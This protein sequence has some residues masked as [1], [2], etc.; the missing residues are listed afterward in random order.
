MSSPAKQ[1]TTPHVI[2]G[3]L[4]DGEVTP[5][6]KVVFS[7]KERSDG[8]PLYDEDWIQNLIFKYPN[9][10]PVQD[11]EPAFFP[12]YPVCRELRTPAG[13]LD[14]LFVS[15]NGGL[16]LV[17]C[18]LWRNPESRREVIGQALDYAKEFSRWSYEDLVDAVRD[19]TKFQGDGIQEAVRQGNEDLDEAA[20]I[21]AVTKNL[22]R[23]RFLVLIVGDGIREGVEEITKF[24]Q[25]HV[26]LDFTFGL[27]ELSV[28]KVTGKDEYFVQPR[29]LANSCTIERAV[30]RVDEKGVVSVNQPVAESKDVGARPDKRTT[31][32]EEQFY[33][34]LTASTN[35]AVAND[36]RQFADKLSKIGVVPAFGSSSLNLRWFPESTQKMNFGSIRKV[37][38]VDT[39]PANWVPTRISRPDIGERYQDALAT[40]VGGS[41][42]KAKNGT[43][44]TL[45]VVRGDGAVVT[46]ADLLTR[47][48]QWFDL[49]GKTQDELIEAVRKFDNE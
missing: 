28:F 7:A 26:G 6:E 39:D 49:I 2:R 21:D 27:V 41:V 11:L 44:F 9:L 43:G 3:T 19:T 24:L 14:N 48:D 12:L 37:G 16:V 36:L 29:I 15:E 4:Q 47:K 1:F 32:S 40:I 45:R 38:T 23:G 22:R 46:L 13:P 31:I 5:L 25:R 33:E 42:L 30:I 17:E 8:S 18:K 35:P 34:E 20:F 10:L